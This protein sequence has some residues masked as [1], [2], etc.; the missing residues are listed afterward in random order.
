MTPVSPQPKQLSG[1]GN[2]AGD[3]GLKAKQTRTRRELGYEEIQC[4]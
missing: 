4:A 1:S 2:N 3:A